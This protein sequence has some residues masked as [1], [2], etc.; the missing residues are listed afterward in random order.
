MI[1]E[2]AVLPVRTEG[3]DDFR[4]AFDAVAPLLRRAEGYLGHV[5][6][7]GVESQQTFTLIVRWRSL[8]DHTP[9]FEASEDHRLFMLGLQD[10]LS[11]EPTV[12]HIEGNFLM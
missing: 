12:Q 10:L 6:G 8:H 5:L 9:V 3:V 4:A 2:I 7:Q 1:H 11:G